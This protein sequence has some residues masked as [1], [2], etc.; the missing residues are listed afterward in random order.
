MA[1]YSANSGPA[2]SY[3]LNSAPAQTYRTVASYTNLAP[4]ES[5]A[6]NQEASVAQGGNCKFLPPIALDQYK[7]NNDPNPEVVRKRPADKVRYT[8]DVAFR[9]LEPPQPPKPGDIVVKQLPNRQIAPAPPLVVRQAPPKPANPPPLVIR[10][11]PPKPPVRVPEKLVLVPGKVLAPPARKVVVERLPPIPPKPQQVFMEKWLPFKQQK[12][13]VVYQPAEPD[14]VLPNPRNLVIQWEAPEVEIKREYKNLGTQLADPEEYARRFNNDLLRHEEFKQAASRFGVPD[15]V[16]ASDS[17]RELGLPELEGDVEAL[18][19][20]D[21]ERV[22]LSEYRSYLSGLG[23]SYDASLF[24]SSAS[25]F[26]FI[27]SPD[28]SNL[29]SIDQ[30]QSTANNL[31][32]GSEKIATDADLRTYFASIDSN[33]DGVI[34]FEEFKSAAF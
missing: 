33:G 6:Y 9:F 14:C 25:A 19:L 5:V 26:G 10:E 24:S 3:V 7:L 34:S 4:A 1:T 22:G 17:H 28:S 20:V 30:A 15:S 32:A 27:T 13:R 31:N 23:V 8:Q 16:V 12:R 18:K 2:L 21:L 29:V 11:Q